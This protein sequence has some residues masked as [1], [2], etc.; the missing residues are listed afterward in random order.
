MKIPF[1]L[2]AE[3]REYC[4][5]CAENGE[6]PWLFRDWLWTSYHWEYLDSL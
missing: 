3:Y 1:H 4:T 6:E 2:R 5:D